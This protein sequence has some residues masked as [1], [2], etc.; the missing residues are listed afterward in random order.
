M[1]ADIEHLPMIDNKNSKPAADDGFEIDE[2]RI[3][4]PRDK[5]NTIVL[6]AVVAVAVIE[7]GR[8][9]V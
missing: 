7:I 9:H 6:Y 1:Y 8:A 3:R 5:K 4:K 2:V